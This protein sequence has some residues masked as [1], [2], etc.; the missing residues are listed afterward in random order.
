MAVE[1]DPGLE[2]ARPAA[3]E[4]ISIEGFSPTLLYMAK[5]Y[6]TTNARNIACILWVACT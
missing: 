4:S 6:N 5:P 1:S 2:M 3:I